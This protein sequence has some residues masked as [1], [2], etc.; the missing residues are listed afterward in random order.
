M[1]SLPTPEKKLS[2]VYNKAFGISFVC[3]ILLTFA[4][5]QGG[6][7]V[8]FSHL[9]LLPGLISMLILVTEIILL[10][11]VLWRDIYL[12][13]LH[14]G[15]YA[16]VGFFTMRFVLNDLVIDQRSAIFREQLAGQSSLWL[17]IAISSFL[18]ADYLSWLLHF[19][20]HKVRGIVGDLSFFCHMTHH[21]M[22]RMQFSAVRHNGVAVFLALAPTTVFLAFLE[23]WNNSLACAILMGFLAQLSLNAVLTPFQ[24]AQFHSLFSKKLRIAVGSFHGKHH[25]DSIGGSRYNFSVGVF[26]IWDDLMGTAVPIGKPSDDKNENLSSP[27][28]SSAYGGLGAAYAGDSKTI[29]QVF[30]LGQSGPLQSYFSTHL[31]RL[32]KNS[33][34]K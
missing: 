34:H 33:S 26:S 4:Y 31:K 6:H 15:T 29:L 11:N 27:D 17:S 2:F 9:G 13:I 21:S 32:T 14:Y 30:S 24:H 1:P 22:D 23:K 3:Q 8:K 28:E 12:F 20:F 7:S 19:M 5:F 25:D 16:L 10:R 18:F